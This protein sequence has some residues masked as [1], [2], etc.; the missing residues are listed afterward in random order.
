MTWQ[1][2]TLLAKKKMED[3]IRQILLPYT[4]IYLA[5]L[6]LKYYFVL[7]KAKVNESLTRLLDLHRERCNRF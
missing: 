2:L 4:F 5:E 1:L 6:K 3:E 7:E